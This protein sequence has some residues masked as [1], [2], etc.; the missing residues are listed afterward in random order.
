MGGYCSPTLA[1]IFLNHYQ[2]LWLDICPEEFKPVYYRTYPIN[3]HW[4]L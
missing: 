2:K 4:Q 1:H 3:G